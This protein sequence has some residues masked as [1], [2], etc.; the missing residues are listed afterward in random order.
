[1]SE[2][3]Y[4]RVSRRAFLSGMSMAAL[5]GVAACSSDEQ[6]LSSDTNSTTSA[7]S[8]SA[9]DSTTDSTTSSSTGESGTALPDSAAAKIAFTF[10]LTSSGGMVR[11]PYIAVWVENSSGELVKTVALWSK[12]GNDRW[13][14]ELTQWYSL[15][16]GTGATSS[17]TK[18]PGSYT[19]DWDGTDADGNRVAAGSYSVFIEASREHGP[20]EIV[21]GTYDFADQAFDQELQASN[22]LTAASIAYTV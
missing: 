8:G 17:G 14:N 9:T 1:M 20:Y 13:I 22:E 16:G 3:R 2:S 18:A 7:S 15:T 10:A 5:A 6:A 4:S 11:N 12:Q 19:V 21:Q